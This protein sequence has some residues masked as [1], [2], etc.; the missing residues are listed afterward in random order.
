MKNT[1]RI[2]KC[3][4]CGVPSR[5]IDYLYESFTQSEDDNTTFEEMHDWFEDELDQWI[6]HCPDCGEECWHLH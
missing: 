5:G 3:E 1:E 2:F 4:N 6:W